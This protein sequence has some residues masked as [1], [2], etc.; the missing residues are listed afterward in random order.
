MSDIKPIETLYKGYR[1]RSRLEARWAVF[2]D[3]LGIKW[4]YEKEG[5]DLGEAGWY[6]PDFWLPK[7]LCFVEIKPRNTWYP[8]ENEDYVR[9]ERVAKL[10]RAFADKVAPIIVFGGVPSS[11]WNGTA[12]CLDI[13][14]SGGGLYEN[15]VGFD[16]CEVLNEAV[17]SFSDEDGKL[18]AGERT[19]W[20]PNWDPWEYACADGKHRRE[21]KHTSLRVYQA[22]IKCRRARFEH[23]ES[24]AL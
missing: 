7:M 23:G 11:G 10:A 24:G 20:G 15:Q 5:Y 19:L 6:L 3:E 12:F 1:F 17:L 2:F 14:D 9:D 16:W 4:E 18:L 8:F 13:T 21:C 22:E